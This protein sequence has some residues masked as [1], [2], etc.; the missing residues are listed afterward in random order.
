M[1]K[2]QGLVTCLSKTI[3]TCRTQLRL[4]NYHICSTNKTPDG[5]YCFIK[6][7][8]HDKDTI[9]DCTKSQDNEDD[10]TSRQWTCSSVRCVWS[11]LHR[12]FGYRQSTWNGRHIIK[13]RGDFKVD[14]NIEVTSSFCDKTENNEET[15]MSTIHC[16]ITHES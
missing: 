14:E 16:C 9:S 10:W 1:Y 2:R 5:L 3:F 13:Y 8:F 7:G 4:G 15:S 11:E 12:F 6:C